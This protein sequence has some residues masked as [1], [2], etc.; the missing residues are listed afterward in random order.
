MCIRDRD[1]NDPGNAVDVTVAVTRVLTGQV[2][3]EQDVTADGYR[4]D[5][6]LSLIH[7]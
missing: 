6:D 1:R 4:P 3:L 5:L 7:I 2:V